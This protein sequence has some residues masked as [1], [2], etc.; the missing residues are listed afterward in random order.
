VPIYAHV[1]FELKQVS[2][3]VRDSITDSMLERF[4]H[5]RHTGAGTQVQAWLDPRDRGG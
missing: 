2:L 4:V 1:S 5:D 3:T